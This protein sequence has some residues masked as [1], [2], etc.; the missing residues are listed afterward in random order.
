[1]RPE[2]HIERFV[3]NRKPRIAVSADI[4]KR[5]LSDSFAA[6]EEAM[7]AKSIVEQ[8]NIW[9]VIM[10]SRITRIA[11]AG[12]IIAVLIFLQDFD[13]GTAWGDVVKALNEVEAVHISGTI[14]ALDGRKERFQWYLRRPSCLY[15]E[16]A[17]TLV[18][19]NGAKRL[20]IDKEK[21]TARFSDSWGPYKPLQEHQMFEVMSLFRGGRAKGYNLKELVHE[22]DETTIVYS[23]KYKK[24]FEGK[25]WVDA[26]TMLPQKIRLAR[27]DG[28]GDEGPES[29]EMGIQALGFEQ[30]DYEV[31]QSIIK[32]S[33]PGK[34][35]LESFRPMPIGSDIEKT[36]AKE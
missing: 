8:P 10:N 1:M 21:K 2:E 3:R 28:T 26:K 19:D 30:E 34:Y 20:T 7:R 32:R 27:I 11:A 35:Q 31:F 24:L 17:K 23:L 6:M 14:T 33:A 5:V 16:S 36:A 25:V 4:D 12:I 29:A 9:K 22:G 15:E 13:G 18:I